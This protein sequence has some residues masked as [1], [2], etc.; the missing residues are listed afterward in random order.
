MDF[1]L[2][3]QEAFWGCFKNILQMALI[4]IP[5]MVF[6]EIFKDM[7]LLD[8]LTSFMTPITSLIGISKEARLPILAGV[9]FGIS[10]GGGI[11]IESAK[12]GKL[13]YDDIYITNLF[14][15][16]CHSVFEDTILFAAIGAKWLPILVV[17]VILA[18]LICAVVNKM[19]K[20]RRSQFIE[21]K[22]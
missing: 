19:I 18:I 14:L 5:L 16:I 1:S 8:K 3:F 10:Y 7:N 11:I 4:V 2:V 15:V 17:R 22:S 20:R 9:A 13:T 12:E 6:I 21:L